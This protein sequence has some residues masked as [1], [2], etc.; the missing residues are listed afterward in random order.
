MEPTP[1]A[2]G[3]QQ[4]LPSLDA[5]NDSENDYPSLEAESIAS[6]V[7]TASQPKISKKDKLKETLMQLKRHISRTRCLDCSKLHRELANNPTDLM[8]Y[9]TPKHC[10]QEHNIHRQKNK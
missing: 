1:G 3:T 9:Q 10:T 6:D 7:S 4:L 8:G 2:S 5:P